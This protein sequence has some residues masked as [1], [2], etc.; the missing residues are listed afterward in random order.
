MK[1]NYKLFKLM[2]LLSINSRATTKEIAKEIKTT[3]QNSSYLISKLKSDTSIDSFVPLID[4]SKFGLDNFCVLIS[5]K[6]G[7]KE[8]SKS[9]LIELKKYKEITGIDFLFGSY[10]LFLRF[11]TPNASNFNKQLRE[12]LNKFQRGIKNYLILTQIV[13][14]HYPRNYLSK[15]R[16]D[17]R[18]ILSGDRE[19]QKIDNLN[20]NIINSLNVNARS[21]FVTIANENNT[22][23]KT[24][25]SRVR[26]LEK[27]KILQGYSILP[28]FNKIGITKYYLFIKYEFLDIDSEKKFQQY[29][30][31]SPF[32]VEYIKTFGEWDT[33]LLIETFKEKE[34]KKMLDELKENFAEIIDDYTFL[35]SEDVKKWK[36]VPEL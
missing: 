12:I 26:N 30:H 24:I 32:I 33:I 14:Y 36:Y 31:F 11:T 21:S 10:D 2:Q 5:F 28:N 22:T 13:L 34:F 4:S 3:Q 18:H 16:S 19:L 20:I 9:L 35:E 1:T 15:K 23:A 27:R 7:S 25:I 6:T 17:T 29:T 8:F